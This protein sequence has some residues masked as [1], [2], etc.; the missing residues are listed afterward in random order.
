M[1]KRAV[2]P[3]LGTR[4]LGSCLRS[5][6]L[7]VVLGGSGVAL[8]QDPFEIH[9]YE[10]EPMTWSQCSLEAHLN[11]DPE[12]KKPLKEHCFRCVTRHI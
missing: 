6:A 12:G 11:F 2:F 7:L 9:V 10:Y 8:A 1:R 4:A 3:C 5:A